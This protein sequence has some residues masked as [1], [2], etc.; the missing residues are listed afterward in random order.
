MSNPLLSTSELPLFNQIKAEH[1][2]PALLAQLN[3]NRA[4]IGTLLKDKQNYTWKNLVLPLERLSDKIHEVWGI[5]K[6]LNAVSD[7]PEWRK[8]YEEALLWVTDY[9]VWLRQNDNLYQAFL[10]IKRSDT[11]KDL[12]LEQKKV[13]EN[14]L[15]DFKLSGVS[16][17][18]KQKERFKLLH[19]QLAKLKTKFSQNVLD[20]TEDWHL[21]ITDPTRLEGLSEHTLA[22]AKKEALQHQQNG[23]R[24]TLNYSC[25]HDIMSYAV[26]RSLREEMYKAYNTLAS[27]QGFS[28]K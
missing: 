23:W 7:T 4:T 14:H 2:K 3:H 26:D 28:K 20:A 5:V 8:E 13:I 17:E 22:Q 1:I 12:S 10:E 19:E 27:D 16:L 24:L 18:S 9:Y 25:Y 15:R 21:L 6:H 11:F